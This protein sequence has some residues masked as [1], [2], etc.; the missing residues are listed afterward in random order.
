MD[1]HHL[2]LFSDTST[3]LNLLN[4]TSDK[5]RGLDMI[6]AGMEFVLAYVSLP[7]CAVYHCVLFLALRPV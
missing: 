5:S 3:I 4:V 6:A 2:A 7:I 1:S